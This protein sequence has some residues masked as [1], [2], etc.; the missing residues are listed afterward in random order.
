MPVY[1]LGCDHWLQ[2]YDL[3]EPM[4]EFKEIERQ[5]KQ[6]FY[7]IVEELIKKQNIVFI[8][9]ECKQKEHTI[10]RALAKENG[11][12]YAEI[13]MPIEERRR[14]GIPEN[15]DRL[16][17]ETKARGHDLRERFM[18]ER[19]QSECRVAG[20]K[21]IVCGSEH[22]ASLTARF[23]KLGERVTARDVTKEAWFDPPYKRLMRGEF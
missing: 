16:G 18:V 23:E 15:Y 13:D 4:P 22:A 7:S 9:E 1:I 14:Q 12:E 19:V 10:P 20:P 17:G 11:C 6:E 8:G 21:L 2:P 5:L 3:C